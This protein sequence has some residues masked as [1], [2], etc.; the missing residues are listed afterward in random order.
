MPYCR[1]CG[2]QLDENAVFCHVCGTPVSSRVAPAMS[3][4][5]PTRLRRHYLLPVS[6]LIGILLVAF[7]AAVLFLAPLFPVNF[8]LSNLVPSKT[9]IDRLSLNFQVDVGQVNV[10]FR[11]LHGDMALVNV[12]ATGSTGFLEDPNHPLTISF[13]DQTVNGFEVVTSKVSRAN[14]P[15]YPNLNV[16]CNVYI[17]PSA[18]LNLSVRSTVGQ[19]AMNTTIPMTFEA[20]NLQTT[21]GS[22]EANLAHVN[23]AG[24]VSAVTTTG[25]VQFL[26]NN[27]NFEGNVSL[28]LR[29]TTGSVNLNVTQNQSGR[30]GGNV[31]VNEITTTG[32]VNLAL[33]MGQNVGAT[34]QAHSTFGSVSVTQTG[35]S[36]NKSPLQSDNYPALSNFIINSATTTGGVHINAHSNSGSTNV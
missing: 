34:I 32:G 11:D 13:S 18:T 33:D 36:A 15:Y 12:T 20:L 30:S 31:S 9:G 2:A 4:R 27:L 16:V 5:R 3:T 1:N 21:T 17:D 23:I 28:G 7:F 14:W 25:S 26:W 10:F 29:S 19:I 35:F 6:I 22:V 24:N 8:S